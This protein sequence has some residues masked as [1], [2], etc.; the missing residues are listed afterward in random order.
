[1]RTIPQIALDLLETSDITLKDGS[2]NGYKVISGVLTKVSADLTHLSVTIEGRQTINKGDTLLL[3]AVCSEPDVKFE[4]SYLGVAIG[5]E[6]VLKFD[7][8]PAGNYFIKVSKQ[9]FEDGDNVVFIKVVDIITPPDGEKFLV[10]SQE[11]VAQINSVK[12]G[13]SVLFDGAQT[14][15]FKEKINV[16]PNTYYGS[17]G[18]QKSDLTGGE[19]LQF[20]P[21]LKGVGLFEAPY[22]GF[23]CKGLTIDGENIAFGRWPKSSAPKKGWLRDKEITLTNDVTGAEFVYKNNH[24]EM[25]RSGKLTGKTFQFPSEPN[26]IECV[27]FQNHWSFCTEFGEWSYD[28]DAKKI[29]VF[30]GDK[31]PDDFRIELNVCDTIFD[32]R[33]VDN[34]KVE[35]LVVRNTKADAINL[36]TA[37]TLQNGKW[38]DDVE[39]TP[40]NNNEILNVDFKNIGRKA[41]A[42]AECD[43]LKA[44]GC[45]YTDCNDGGMIG[46]D[47]RPSRNVT[48]TFCK[49]YNI[50]VLEGMARLEV[51]Y[52]LESGWA[53]YNECGSTKEFHDNTFV[54]NNNDE[55]LGA[56]AYRVGGN[57]HLTQF[58]SIKRHGLRLNEL[59]GI[60]SFN[61]YSPFIVRVNRKIIGNYIE[62]TGQEEVS[63]AFGFADS[64]GKNG[65]QANISLDDH[66]DRFSITDNILVKAQG[67][68]AGISLHNAT[69]V[70][71]LRNTCYDNA[72]GIEVLH[73]SKGAGW[74]IES[75]NVKG[76]TIVTKS[77]DQILFRIQGLS[78][79]ELKTIA[80]IDE[81]KYAK[82]VGNISAFN[83]V[84]RQPVNGQQDTEYNENIS[85]TDWQKFGHDAGGK[86]SSVNHPEFTVSP[87]GDNIFKGLSNGISEDGGIKFSAVE[88]SQFDLQDLGLAK[89]WRE[90]DGIKGSG[91]KFNAPYN[92]KFSAKV[93]KPTTVSVVLAVFGS[94]SDTGTEPQKIE[95]TPD[96][97]DYSLVF[98]PFKDINYTYAVFQFKEVVDFWIYNP[99][100]KTTEITEVNADDFSKIIFN[101]SE[102]DE[103]IDSGEFQDIDGN[104]GQLTLKSKQAL[105]LIK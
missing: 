66:T 94:S 75:V 33:N 50:G 6:K 23:E 8:A 62:G 102:T 101:E 35:N 43:G 105:V 97:K 47:R 70:D 5:A 38:N 22:A 76:N 31:N 17:Y 82:P 28:T 68:A 9:R 91:A 99:E 96:K 32:F 4:W 104:K 71:V 11:K 81:N 45:T 36:G 18:S 100:F 39:R 48:R 77:K 83:A 12:E 65:T 61:N 29:Y 7:N 103:T 42:Y 24:F 21:S 80:V 13:I 25:Y 90:S 88:G 57:N 58:N 20:I 55:N 16:K 1:M 44:S 93:S 98:K 92:L 26:F 73:D 15:R 59:G 30:L 3:T 54:S 19:L 52:A 49:G 95:L 53:F 2:G 78:P 72:C 46:N 85:F 74:K 34:S 40:C 89:Y 37:P 87:F 27:F 86:F 14:F 64:T 63:S 79:D 60:Y 51:G 84:Y 67:Q 69:V 56:G 41:I 10:D